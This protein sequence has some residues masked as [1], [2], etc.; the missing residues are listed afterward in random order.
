MVRTN[1]L[2]SDLAW[3]PVNAVNDWGA[4]THN[5]VIVTNKIKKQH[6]VREHID[7]ATSPFVITSKQLYSWWWTW[8]LLDPMELGK[9]CTTVVRC[10]CE[11]GSSQTWRTQIF[12]LL[13]GTMQLNFQLSGFGGCN[14]FYISEYSKETEDDLTFFSSCILVNICWQSIYPWKESHR[15]Q[16]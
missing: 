3:H 8:P 15:I 1:G 7:L 5:W 6:G 9:E 12:M 4:V 13:F 11:N 2:G 10:F 16:R 14:V